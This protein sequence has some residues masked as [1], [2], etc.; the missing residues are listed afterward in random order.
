MH[1]MP[2][3]RLPD[4]PARAR[5]PHAQA[6]T[7]RPVLREAHAVHG[8]ALAAGEAPSRR[9]GAPNPAS[10]RLDEEGLAPCGNT[11]R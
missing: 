2:R 5:M 11:T 6:E 3:G 10:G 1:E 4:W 8:L 9:P 7:D